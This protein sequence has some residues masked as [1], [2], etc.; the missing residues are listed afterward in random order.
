MQIGILQTG[1]F[2]NALAGGNDDY[3]V[4]FHQM[5]AGHGF[6][7]RTFNVV[8]MEFPGSAHDADGWLI[9]GSPHGAYEDLTFIPPLEDLIRAIFAAGRPLVGICFGHQIVAQALG[10][11]VE[12]FDGGWVAGHQVYDFSGAEIAMNAWHQD[13]VVAVP[14][15]A[16]VLAR[17]ATCATAALLYG[18]QALT[19]QAHPEFDRNAMAALI[20]MRGPALPPAQAEAALSALS[21]PNDNDIIADRIAAFFK[22]DHG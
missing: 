4:L 12:K 7:F 17:S 13:Q 22:V 1:H 5:L 2:L 19:I 21:A 15:G 20:D 10:G 9:T 16:Q 18:G 3:D 6:E 11:R 14:E 8:D